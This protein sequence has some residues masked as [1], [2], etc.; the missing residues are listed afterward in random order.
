MGVVALDLD[1]TA[2]VAYDPET[3]RIGYLVV[4]PGPD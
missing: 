1:S 4:R 2:T 3:T